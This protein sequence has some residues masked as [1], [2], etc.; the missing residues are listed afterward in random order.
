MQDQT[1]RN[2]L[3]IDEEIYSEL[4]CEF[5]ST[6]CI[7]FPILSRLHNTIQFLARGQYYTLTI[8]QFRATLRIYGDE[9]LEMPAFRELSVLWPS[10]LTLSYCWSFKRIENYNASAMKGS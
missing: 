10:R 5:L 6:F 8:T 7:K 4:K 1:W 2:M 3:S 9:F